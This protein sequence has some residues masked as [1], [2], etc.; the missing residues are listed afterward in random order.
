MESPLSPEEDTLGETFEEDAD[1]TA[2]LCNNTNI[3]VHPNE[4][5]L[6]VDIDRSKL[7]KLEKSK[8]SPGHTKEDQ[9]RI[10]SKNRTM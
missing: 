9:R 1:D 6:E 10:E 7:E 2:M 3:E 4:K 8:Q 5:D